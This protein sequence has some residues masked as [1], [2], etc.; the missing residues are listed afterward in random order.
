[1]VTV[2][3]SRFSNGCTGDAEHRHLE[4]LVAIVV[5]I[6]NDRNVNRGE[7]LAVRKQ[8]ATGDRTDVVNAIDRRCVLRLVEDFRRPVDVPSVRC[9]PTET[10]PASSLT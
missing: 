8:H 6:I 9:S 2:A 3:V 5:V 10:V 4:I 7:V 1:M